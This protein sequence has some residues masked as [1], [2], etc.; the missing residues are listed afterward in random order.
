MGFAARLADSRIGVGAVRFRAAVELRRR[1]RGSVAL[2]VLAGVG[3]G[4]ALAMFAGARRTDTALDRFVAGAGQQ[5]DATIDLGPGEDARRIADL[6]RVTR[7]ATVTIVFLRPPAPR[8]SRTAGADSVGST[9]L[10]DPSRRFLAGAIVVVGRVPDAG[11]PHEVAIDEAAAR[12]RG[13]RVGDRLRFGIPSPE[14]AFAEP[15]RVGSSSDDPTVELT[16]TGIVR[17][18][19]D[20]EPVG[21][22]IEQ[23]AYRP[24]DDMWLTP[25]F[26]DAHVDTANFSVAAIWL[27]RGPADLQAFTETVRAVSG[28]RAE[29]SAAEFD[30]ADVIADAERDQCAGE[31]VTHRG[32]TRDRGCAFRRRARVVAPDS[33]R[34]PRSADV[35]RGRDDQWTTGG[36]RDGAGRGGRDGR[37]DRRAA[38]GDRA[39]FEVPGRLR[40]PSRGR[41]W[42]ASRPSGVRRGRAG[43]RRHVRGMVGVRSLAQRRF[44]LGTSGHRRTAN[45][46]ACVAM[47]V[48]SATAALQ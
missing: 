44:R 32:S 18:P 12:H 17:L 33:C 23:A 43:N 40:V 15:G 3:A 10:D 41:S 19:Q 7:T 45:W 47:V 36:R 26:L 14:E 21:A 22:G 42:S 8:S 46:P 30:T 25:A 28:G 20:L 31:C 39:V 11:M 4:V 2:A 13:W 24:P 1:W 37:R 48:R 16:V 35:T 6:P 27:A 5:F 34:R 9:V 29:V 38:H